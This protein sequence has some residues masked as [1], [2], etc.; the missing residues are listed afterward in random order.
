[1]KPL[2]VLLYAVPVLTAVGLAGLFAGRLATI[3]NG[4]NVPPSARL[5]QP[6]PDLVLESL[7]PEGDDLRTADLKG[8]PYVLNVWAEWC[9]PCKIEHP[10]LQAM[11]GRGIAVYGIDYKDRPERARAFLA[12]RGNPF[13]AVGFDNDGRTGIELGIFGVPETFVVD[14]E[15]FIRYRHAGP[16]SV[17]HLEQ[18][19]LPLLANLAAAQSP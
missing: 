7:F 5:D 11:A 1:M 2:R 16:L 12:E 14:G 15:G 8:E 19:L 18:A 17:A 3:D 10:Q 9:G 13:T 4:T 6:M